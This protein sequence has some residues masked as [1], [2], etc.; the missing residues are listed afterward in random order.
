VSESALKSCTDWA[1]QL[2]EEAPKNRASHPK[3]IANPPTERFLLDMDNLLWSKRLWHHYRRTRWGNQELESA[4]QALNFST[5]FGTMLVKQISHPR[6]WNVTRVDVFALVDK[7]WLMKSKIR[8][9]PCLK[10]IT[11]QMAIV[12][13]LFISGPF[14]VTNFALKQIAAQE[15][16]D[17][18]S[19]HVPSAT[20]EQWQEAGGYICWSFIEDGFML[21]G[22]ETFDQ[23]SK[24]PAFRIDT[25]NA[26]LFS[27]LELPS[28]GVVADLSMHLP[29]DR[30]LELLAATKNLRGV[31]FFSAELP[32]ESLRHFQGVDSLEYVNLDLVGLTD[33][34]FK[35]FAKNEN[36]RA[37]SLTGSYL[38]DKGLSSL[39]KLENLEFLKLTLSVSVTD[40]GLETFRRCRNLRFL[41]LDHTE[42]TSRGLA[43]LAKHQSLE[44]LSLRGTKVDSLAGIEKFTNL[45]VLD[46]AHSKIGNR[47]L[48]Q[49][50]A[51]QQLRMVFV[52]GCEISDAGVKSLANLRNLEYLNVAKT[53]VSEAG[54][55]E[56]ANAL[57]NCTIFPEPTTDF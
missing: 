10:R 14:L 43:E 29:T 30:E 27:R 28:S 31:F 9:V 34:G 18:A 15:I 48:Q 36:L 57:P 6:R 20:A 46:L 54:L 7:G 55:R 32:E 33:V 44:Q 26:D 2:V 51:L 25:W 23:H 21:S 56:L 8:Y 38:T 24:L 40:K 37:L 45:Q 1:A 41:Y 3:L 13:G 50:A 22:K 16:G 52:G 4:L 12:V 11:I 39:E 49:L 35:Y 53:K 42:V 5:L 17:L 47:D 19:Q